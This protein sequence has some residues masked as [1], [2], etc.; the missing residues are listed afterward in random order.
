MVGELNKE[1]LH[2]KYGQIEFKQ[3]VKLYI[4]PSFALQ[5]GISEREYE[6]QK[7]AKEIFIKSTLQ[8]YLLN[9]IKIK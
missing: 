6:S 9:G 7:V 4:F 8:I 2:E 1:K 5:T 3:N